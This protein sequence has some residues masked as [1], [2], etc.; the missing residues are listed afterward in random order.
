MM[1]KKYRQA[2]QGG[3]FEGRAAYNLDGIRDLVCLKNGDVASVLNAE[4]YN[5]FAASK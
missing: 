5:A 2:K 4:S 1:D 3:I